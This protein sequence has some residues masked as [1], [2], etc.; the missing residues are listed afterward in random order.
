MSFCLILLEA[1]NS[2]RFSH[3]IT[4][5]FIEFQQWMFLCPK[6]SESLVKGFVMGFTN[7]FVNSC[8]NGFVAVCLISNRDKRKIK[9]HKLNLSSV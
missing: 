9:R 3:K 8:V 6:F 5:P 7:S 1:G 2:K 4:K